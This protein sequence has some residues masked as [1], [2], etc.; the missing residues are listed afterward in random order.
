MFHPFSKRSIVK[1]S[2]Q[3]GYY[4]ILLSEERVDKF[5]P[6]EQDLDVKKGELERLRD[7]KLIGNTVRSRAISKKEWEKNI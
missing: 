7:N 3:Y 6:Y 4:R 1:F 5:S 2:F